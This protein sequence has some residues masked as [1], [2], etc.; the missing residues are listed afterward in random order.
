MSQQGP[1]PYLNVGGIEIANAARTLSYL[2][3]GLGDTIKGVWELQAGDVCSVLY[4]LGGS[5]VTFVSPSADPAPWY[6]SSEPGASEFLGLILLDMKGYDS[7]L[8]RSV[9][10]RVDTFGGGQLG[11][12]Q[13]K[14]RVWNFRA[15]LISNGDAGAEYGLRWL[16]HIL[17]RPCVGCNGT[18]LKVRITC[19]PED[20]FSDD[21][22][23]WTSYDVA[24]TAGPT[25]VD[26]WGPGRRSSQQDTL[27]ACRDIAII[28][29]QLTAAN[30]YLYKAAEACL[31]S[32]PTL[33]EG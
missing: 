9:T 11:G 2:R 24:L 30:P 25:E 3:A 22:G 6:D 18:Y 20:T 5:P 31:A 13:R 23:E 19:P 21:Q 10:S 29:F 8:T 1:L 28:E 14:P 16:T 4:R 12:Q 7:I 32:S 26:P 33:M 17:I 15:A 27:G